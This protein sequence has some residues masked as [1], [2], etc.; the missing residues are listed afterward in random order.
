MATSAG[1]SSASRRR[2]SRSTGCTCRA[3]GSTRCSSTCSTGRTA[4]A[5][6][7]SPRSACGR[8]SGRAGRTSRSISSTSPATST[9][10]SCR[11]RWSPSCGRSCKFDGIEPLVAQMRADVEEARAVL[12]RLPDDAARDRAADAPPWEPRDNAPFAAINADPRGHAAF[13]A[14]ARPRRKRRRRSRGFEARWADDGF[15][16]GAAERRADGAFLGMAGIARC[17]FEVPRS[18]PAWR[19]AGASPART[20]A[21]AMPPRRRAA[22][23]D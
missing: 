22:W 13:P 10:P 21:R 4:G 17:D 1:A 5:T 15:C 14:A 2:T 20:G 7:V 18:T 6:A 23:L 16:F 9:A 8:P 11:W 12:A 3:S 19:S